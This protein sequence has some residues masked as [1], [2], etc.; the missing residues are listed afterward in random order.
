MQHNIQLTNKEE[1]IKCLS[2]AIR[3]QAIL[4]E[5]VAKNTGFYTDEMMFTL[6]EQAIQLISL[7]K[8]M[9]LV[10]KVKEVEEKNV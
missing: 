1:Y 10:N 9:G 5:N 2:T 8:L 4:V 7:V 3:A 6:N